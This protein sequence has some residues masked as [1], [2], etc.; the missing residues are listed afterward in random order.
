MIEI[1][2]KFVWGWNND[3]HTSRT[4]AQKYRALAADAQEQARSLEQTYAQNQAYLFRS[5]AEKLRQTS[6]AAQAAL[7]D[8]QARRAANGGSADTNAALQMQL[9]RQLQD[10]N[11]QADLQ[12]QGAAQANHFAQKWQALLQAAHQYRKAAKKGGRLGSLGRALV[13]LF[14]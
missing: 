13:S 7:A 6:Q 9:A 11:V 4:Q 2:K 1:G 8:Q 14:Q 5:A 10:K 3:Q 12:T